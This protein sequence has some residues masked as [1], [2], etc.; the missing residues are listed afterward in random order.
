M[1][2][3]LR[4]ST[5]LLLLLA[6]TAAYAANDRTFD[7]QLPAQPRG[8]V[9][10]SNVSGK[11]EVSGWDRAEVSVHAELGSNVE[12]VEVSSEAGHTGIKVIL[13]HTSGHGS[14]AQVQVKIPKDS[15]LN[16]SAVSADVTT[17]GVLGMQRLNAVSGGISAELGGAD[18]ELKTVSGDIQLHGHGQP[19]RLRVSTVSGDV[20]LEHGAGDVEVSSVNGT[21]IVSLD[22]ARSLRARTT[23][24]NLRFTGKLVRGAELEATSVSGDLQVRASADG[25]FAYEVSSFSGDISDCFKASPERASQYGPG[26]RLEGKLGEGAGH[27]RLKTMSGD[28]QL[29][30]RP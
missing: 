13:P 11:V 10:V 25:G 15:E 2:T 7:R 16:V 28:V 21:L 8:V 27:V 12:R 14:D 24:G 9:D 20:H 26:T 22:S 3:V 5:A 19:A 23:S 1:R 30:D 29:C 6:G 17:Q 18:V 4:L